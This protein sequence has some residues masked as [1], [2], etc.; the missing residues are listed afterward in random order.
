MVLVSRGKM[1]RVLLPIGTA[2]VQATG[3]RAFRP[4]LFDGNRDIDGPLWQ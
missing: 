3:E 1:L 2:K 4:P